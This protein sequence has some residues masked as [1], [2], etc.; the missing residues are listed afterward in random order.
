M[1]GVVAAAAVAV[2]A[3]VAWLGT[4]LGSVGGTTAGLTL[5]ATVVSGGAIDT[6]AVRRNIELQAAQP[7]PVTTAIRQVVPPGTPDESVRQLALTL[8]LICAGRAPLPQA[9][10]AL[11]NHGVDA[12]TAGRILDATRTMLVCDPTATTT[13]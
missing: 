9:M 7:N 1:P 10:Q 8:N 2:V 3:T 11:Q 6:D 13:P 4:H 5:K 12:A